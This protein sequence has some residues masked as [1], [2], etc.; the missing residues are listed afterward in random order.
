VLARRAGKATPGPQRAR[1]VA[2]PAPATAAAAAPS[3]VPPRPILRLRRT[4][5]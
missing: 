4:A 5:S 2:P 1:G 3:R